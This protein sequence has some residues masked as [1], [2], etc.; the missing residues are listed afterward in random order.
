MLSLP[1]EIYQDALARAKQD[2]STSL[3][4]AKVRFWEVVARG[5][6]LEEWYLV[7]GAILLVILAL[8]SYLF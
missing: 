7:S 3:G 2:E 5:Q 6:G 4:Q 8:G 1:E